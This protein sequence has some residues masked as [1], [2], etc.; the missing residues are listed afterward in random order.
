MSNEDA[1]LLLLQQPNPQLDRQACF[2]THG[3]IWW[4]TLHD[5][6]TITDFIFFRKPNNLSMRILGSFPD[7]PH[8]NRFWCR[9]AK[10][11]HPYACD[12]CSYV[13]H[14]NVH[15][16]VPRTA[17]TIHLSLSSTST[18]ASWSRMKRISR[19]VNDFDLH[20]SSFP[21]RRKQ[22]S[23]KCLD[24]KDIEWFWWTAVGTFNNGTKEQ[25]DINMFGDD[26][27]LL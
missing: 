11:V 20:R 6:K 25:I 23:G 10:S 15:K 5:W 4:E 13:C 14:N 27:A 22:L 21:R 19:V 26:D 7:A 9:W 8:P 2:N 17:P 3:I 18:K 12:F 24:G 1:H 16:S